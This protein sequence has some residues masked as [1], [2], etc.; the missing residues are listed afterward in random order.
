MQF[1]DRQIIRRSLDRDIPFRHPVLPLVISGPTLVTQNRL[2]PFQIQPRAASINQRLKNQLHLVTDLEN[3]VAAVFHLI[4]GVLVTEAASI[5]FL[6]I[7]SKAEAG[8][9]NPTLADL[10]QSPYSRLGA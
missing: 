3:E 7:Q 4:I 1:E 9:V 2:D 6:G 8:A 10:A 5:P